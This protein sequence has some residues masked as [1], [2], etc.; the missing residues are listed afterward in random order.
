[1]GDREFIQ[2]V[3]AVMAISCELMGGLGNQLFQIAT[4]LALAWQNDD[5][6]IFDLDSH[7]NPLQGNRAKVYRQTIYR[8][9]EVDSLYWPKYRFIKFQEKGHHY[10]PISYRDNLQLI[11]YFQSEKYFLDCRQKLL[12]LFAMPIELRET[13]TQR[14]GDILQQQTCSIHIRRGDYLKFSKNHPPCTLEYYQKA[15][16]LFPDCIFPIFSDDLDWCRH[17]FTDDRFIFIENSRD[18]LDL[19][20][21]SMCRHHIIAN[22][23]FSWWGSWLNDRPNKRVVAPVNWF[24]E[25]LQHL[26]SADIYPRSTIVM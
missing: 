1:M 16:D 6:A 14:Y 21:M 13:L 20:L 25:G 22:S 5:Q 9:L 19:Y 4:T 12:E 17:H 7:R 11:G 8:N 15:I 23:S 10:Q 24:G 2:E 3:V 18:D 26:N